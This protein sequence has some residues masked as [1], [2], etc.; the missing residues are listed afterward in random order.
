MRLKSGRGFFVISMFVGGVVHDDD[1]R[2]RR[3]VCDRDRCLDRF[4][5][6]LVVNDDG[7]HASPRPGSSCGSQYR[8]L[9]VV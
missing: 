7:G 6:R 8:L 1:L 9:R 2:V 3:R 4:F 5:G